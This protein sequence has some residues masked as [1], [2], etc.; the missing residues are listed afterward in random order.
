LRK[1]LAAAEQAMPPALDIHVVLD[2]YATCK[3][4]PVRIWMAQDPGYHLHLT[5]TSA[6]W[7]NPS[8][9]T[10]GSFA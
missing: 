6:S 1:F 4:P 10:A 3:A 7:L 5:P 2:N 9:M 8:R